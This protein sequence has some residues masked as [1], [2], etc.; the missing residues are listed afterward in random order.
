MTKYT[1]EGIIENCGG[2][3]VIASHCSNLKPDSVRKWV[4]RGI[5]EKHWSAIIKLHGWLLNANQLHKLNESV[6]ND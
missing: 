1:I 3:S 6:R 2:S 5:P 4:S